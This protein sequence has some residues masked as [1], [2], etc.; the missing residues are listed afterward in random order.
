MV[1]VQVWYYPFEQKDLSFSTQKKM[2]I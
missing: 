2:D 1:L